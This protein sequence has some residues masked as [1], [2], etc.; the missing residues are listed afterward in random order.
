MRYSQLKRDLSLD[1]SACRVLAVGNFRVIYL[2]SERKKMVPTNPPPSSRVS[3]CRRSRGHRSEAHLSNHIR[4]MLLS[5]MRIDF[6]QERAVVAMAKPPGNGT[7]VYAGL[8]ASCSEKMTQCVGGETWNPEFLA[9]A[10]DKALRFFDEQGASF[11]YNLFSLG[12][13]SLQELAHFPGHRDLPGFA[14]LGHTQMNRLA[15]KVDVGPCYICR[16]GFSGA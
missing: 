12:F 10:R 13:H 2:G 1:A 5:D 6:Q 9:R 11:G 8:K 16:F 4:F 14:V 15:V 7:D 3:D